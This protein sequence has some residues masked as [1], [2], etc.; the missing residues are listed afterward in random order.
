MIATV[1]KGV[2]YSAS[3]RHVC[4]MCL[5]VLL[6]LAAPSICATPIAEFDPPVSALSWKRFETEHFRITYTSGL[7]R[8]A[9]AVAMA[10]E[11]AYEPVTRLYGYR[12][13]GKTEIIVR[14]HGD[15]ANGFAA[16]YDNRMEIWASALDYEFRGT[17]NWICDVTTHEFTHLVQLGAS[18]KTSP[19]IPQ[20]YFQW[21]RLEPEARTD[22]AEGLPNTLVSYAVPTVSIPMWFAE[23]VAQFQ[24]QGARHDRWDAHR[25]M[26]VRVAVLADSQLSYRQMEGFYDPDGREAEMVYNHG[27]SFVRWLAATYGDSSLRALSRDMRAWH[28]WDFGSALKQL[29]GKPGPRVYEEWLTQ[30][31]AGY[32][33]FVAERK[34]QPAGTLLERPA[35]RPG[36]ESGDRPPVITPGGVPA[37]Y[38]PPPAHSARASYYHAAPVWSPDGALLAYVSTDGQDYRL[39]SVWVRKPGTGEL[40]VAPG[41]FR[42]SSTVSWFPD[43]RT[44]VFSRAQRDDRNEWRYND[45]VKADLQTGTVT[46]LT[47]QWR[48]SYPA[49][50]PDGATVAFV[51][52]ARGS[53]NLMLANAD[54]SNVRPLTRWDDGTQVFSPKWSP[55]GTRLAV[56][57]ARAGSRHIVV[58]RV[59]R[60][61]GGEV[62][63]TERVIASSDDD[64]DPAF[65]RDGTRV[66][67]SS[68]ADGVFNLYEF[69]L[70]RG[71]CARL[72][73]VLGGAFHPDV[74]PDGRIAYSSYES[75][76]YVIRIIPADAPR[77]P[78][79][80]DIFANRIPEQG[81][82]PDSMPEGSSVSDIDRRIPHLQRPSI[83]PRFGRYGNQWRVGAYAFSSDIWDDVL[84][85]GGVWAAPENRDYDAFVTA[86]VDHMTPVPVL[87]DVVRTVRH[88]KEDT[89]FAGRLRLDGITYGLNAVSLTL[90]PRVFS[91]EIDLH[92]TY[93]RFDAAIDQTLLLNG[94]RTYVGYNY[95]YYNGFAAG[96]SVSSSAIRPFT[97]ADIA[98]QGM[99]WSLRYDRWW[100][101]YFE[102]FDAG[103]GLLNE[104][105]TPYHYN[106]V[107][108]DAAWYLPT[109]WREEHTVGVEGRVMRIDAAVD[110]FFYEGIGGIIGLR[111]YT[112]YQLQGKQ[113]A[114]GRL[115]YRF[116][117]LTSIDRKLG[118]VYFDK[119][120]GTVFAEAGRVWR[121]SYPSS[122]TPGLKRDVGAEIRADLFS[123]YG[124]PSRF[125]FSAARA[126]DAAPHS[127]RT[128]FYLTL[129]FGYL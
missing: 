68:A 124:Y 32:E 81:T 86:E 116:P 31:R 70:E 100:N 27:Y 114:W 104:V 14:D 75:A 12:P 37:A 60:A 44:V 21:F 48:A 80:A 34:P 88:T 111:G 5:V 49:V 99:K 61:S 129:L 105:Y 97:T 1:R 93:Q 66:V 58:Y 128:K 39:G 36:A 125:S 94:T 92:S 22:V 10:A 102:D 77:Y 42:A 56:S 50:S 84:L 122:W 18:L 28:R 40:T 16:Y 35:S 3:K 89:T 110:S 45:L 24:A 123:F 33:A 26:I 8:V 13:S 17:H 47:D 127:D 98:P 95:T 69:D 119:I 51:R 103:T 20:V 112:Y 107:S 79:S 19:A 59:V 90:K 63:E 53:T 65:S 67:F 96:A 71:S 113:T 41:S 9:S 6:F 121:D 106:Q 91:R 76:G 78:V 38:A 83:L 25:D 43:G 72:T 46:K 30:L 4:G 64:R 115:L 55:D 7:E 73:N 108:C 11:Q 126:L 15:F 57:L 87:F 74:A 29:T 117:L 54:G 120:Y 82:F 85:M 62:L 23:G 101:W 118:P 52:N 109:P 2:L